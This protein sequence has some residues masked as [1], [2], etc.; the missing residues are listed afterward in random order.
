MENKINIKKNGFVLCAVLVVCFICA[1]S[2]KDFD[3]VSGGGSAMRRQMDTNAYA[4]QALYR[5]FADDSFEDYDFA[6]E[7]A[8]SAAYPSSSSEIGETVTSAP[9]YIKTANISL[10][11]ESFDADLDFIKNT[12]TNAGGY[13][14]T[15]N[16]YAKSS[17]RNAE[18]APLRI[19]NA[20]IR[21]LA[22]YYEQV[23][24]TLD[25]VGVLYASSENSQEVS[26]EYFNVESR[27]ATSKTEKARLLEI[28][29]QET[30]VRSVIEYERRL[31]E[32]S[33]QVDIYETRLAKIKDQTAYSTITLNITEIIKET[34]KKPEDP[35]LQKLKDAFGGSAAATRDFF[36]WLLVFLVTISLPL[37]IVIAICAAVFWA[38][39]R[40]S[41]KI[42]PTP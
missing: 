12:V 25:N 16:M 14:E 2:K 39:G 41:K 18:E 1:C 32:V 20:T 38:R 24:N 30:N 37:C 4:P 11:S 22:Q 35:F 8:A 29:Q 40:K 28:I 6:G 3:S 27:L 9:M 19:Y 7:T 36:Q 10:G 26:A 33:A 23:K 17:A 31:S 5:D 13:F 42:K 15:S 21:V 34:E